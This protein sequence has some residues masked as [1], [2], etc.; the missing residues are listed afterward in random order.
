MTQPRFNRS[1]SDDDDEHRQDD[2]QIGH[3]ASRAARAVVKMRVVKV[4]VVTR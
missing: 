3:R 4:R 1:R 2:E